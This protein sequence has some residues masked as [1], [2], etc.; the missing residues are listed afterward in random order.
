MPR[1]Y[2]LTHAHKAIS[3]SVVWHLAENA[4]VEYHNFKSLPDNFLAIGDSACVTSPTYGWGVN[5][6][7][8]MAVTLA[9]VLDSLKGTDIPH[10][11]AKRFFKAV[12]LRTTWSWYVISALGYSSPVHPSRLGRQVGRWVSPNASF[13]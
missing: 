8:V 12:D 10:G 13:E 11:F 9:G 4:L 1:S 2:V 7:G 3:L 6:A 5:R